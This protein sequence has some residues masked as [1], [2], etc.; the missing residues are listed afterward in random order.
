MNFMEALMIV[1]E[2]AEERMEDWQAWELKDVVRANEEAISIIR[3]H[4]EDSE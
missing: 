4:I 3:N 1:L 2:L